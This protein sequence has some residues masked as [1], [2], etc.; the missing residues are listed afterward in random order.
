M[1]DD[2]R[3]IPPTP[4]SDTGEVIEFDADDLLEIEAVEEPELLDLDG[5]DLLLEE[6]EPANDGAGQAWS[7]GVAEAAPAE[8]AAEPLAEEAVS[9]DD[10]LLGD[11]DD[12]L[13]DEP[14]L[15]EGSL[16]GGG[17]EADTAPSPVVSREPVAVEAAEPEVLGD[18]SPEE[19]LPADFHLEDPQADTLAEGPDTMVDEGLGVALEPDDAAGLE[20]EAGAGGDVL[21][22]EGGE[23]LLPDADDDLLMDG[24]G[25]WDRVSMTGLQREAAA[26]VDGMES[27]AEARLDG[28]TF[29]EGDA[30][31]D[32]DPV[33]GEPG[34]M[35]EV[36]LLDDPAD[37]LSAA[38]AGEPADELSAALAG[39]PADE[40]SDESADE[41]MVEDAAASEAESTEPVTLPGEG[42]GAIDLELPELPEELAARSGEWLED[43][44]VWRGELQRLVRSNKWR[45]VAALSA[46]AAMRASFAQGATLA[47]ILQDLGRLYRDRLRD[48]VRAV[49]AFEALLT[50]E[51]GQAE[52]LSWLHGAWEEDGRW[53]RICTTA[54]RA[55]EA[56]WDR[57][58]RLRLTR[59]AADTAAERLGRLDLA[60]AAWEQLWSLGDGLEEATSAL[61]S[62]YRRT[63]RWEELAVFIERQVESADAATSRLLRRELAELRLFALDDADGAERLL[64]K[65]RGDSPPDAV[66][67]ELLV[68]IRTRLQRW[69]A[70]LELAE[71]PALDDA[72]RVD[73]LHRIAA[74]VREAG[75]EEDA[76]RLIDRV[77]E[78]DPRDAGALS[79]RRAWLEQ[80]GE[81][82]ALAD[83]L[84]SRAAEAVQRSEELEL[85]REAAEIAENRLEN[86][87]RAVRLRLAIRE[88]APED[89]EVLADLDRL[90][91]ATGQHGERRAV[92][93]EQARRAPDRAARV[94]ALLS[95]ARLCTG[96]GEDT[97]RAREAL[98]E[99]LRLEPSH[100][101]ALEASAAL[102]RQ[103][104]DR[105]A[106]LADMMRRYALT[107]DVEEA[108]Q[109]GAE[110]A[111]HL[112][113]ALE[114][115]ARAADAWLLVV[116]TSTR[117]GPALEALDGCL[118]DAGAGRRRALV[119]L[120]ALQ[121]VEGEEAR[122]GNL[123]QLAG[124][125][126]SSGEARLE[127]GVLE[128]LLALAEDP[129]A[130]AR[131]LE[132]YAGDGHP[133]EALDWLAAH[134]LREAPQAVRLARLEAWGARLAEDDV[135]GRF[136]L[137]RRRFLLGERRPD[138]IAELVAAG[139]AVGD[140]PTVCWLLRLHLLTQSADER[141]S[142]RDLLAELLE[143]DLEGADRAWLLRTASLASPGSVSEALEE[144]E[145]LAEQ[146]GRHEDLLAL[147]EEQALHL[148]GDAAGRR[149]ALERCEALARGPLDDPRRAIGA[150][151]RRIALD[152]PD[153]DVVGRLHTLCTG[154][155]FESALAT[156][157]GDLA[158]VA[159]SLEVR[160]HHLEEEE[161]VR[162]ALLDDAPGAFRVQ[163]QRFRLLPEA[164]FDAVIEA[165]RALGDD[166]ATLHRVLPMIE[167]SLLAAA[168]NRPA[169]AL[170]RLSAVWAQDA[171]DA[172]RG[173]ELAAEALMADPDHEDGDVHLVTMAGKAGRQEDLAMVLRIAAARASDAERRA[174]LLR[175][176]ATLYAGVLERPELAVEV[177]QR[178]LRLL[179]DDLEIVG[180]LADAARDAEDWDSL[181]R[182]LRRTVVL[183]EDR[184][185]RVA[186]QLEVATLCR[187]QLDDPEGAFTAFAG[188]LEIDPEHEEARER[189]AELVEELR[190][191]E[192]RLRWLQLELMSAEGERA[193]EL[194]LAMAALQQDELEDAEAAVG[195]LLD[196]VDHAGP[197]DEAWTRLVTL[198][199]PLGRW[200]D[201]AELQLARAE[202]LEGEERA[203]A[204]SDALR[205]CRGHRDAFESG[206]LT[207][208][209]RRALAVV[210]DDP[211]IRRDLAATLVARGALDAFAESLEEW[212]RTADSADER[213]RLLLDRA[214]V[215]ANDLD[216]G[217]GADATLT[218]AARGDGV[219]Y[220]A[221]VAVPLFQ[222]RLARLRGDWTSYLT[223]R[224]A[225]ARRLD[226]REAAL[227]F[228]H[229][230]EVCD[231]VDGLQPRMVGFYREA[232]GLDPENTCA[233]EALRGI[234]RRLKALRPAAALLPEDGERDLTLEQ[235]VERLVQ[236]ADEAGD[237][238]TE[239][240]WL[241][242]ATAIDPDRA[243]L[244]RR[245]AELQERGGEP[246]AAVQSR[247]AALRA[248]ERTTGLQDEGLR[249]DE[250]Q[251]LLAIVPALQSAGQNA[252]FAACA[253]RSFTLAPTSGSALYALAGYLLAQERET[254]LLA[255]LGELSPE[256]DDGTP[257]SL[258]SDLLCLQG[259]ALR[260]EEREEDARRALQQAIGLNPL[261]L[262][263]LDALA[264]LE[265]ESGHV[266]EALEL[267]LR[268]L[269]LDPDRSSRAPRYF[270]VGLLFEDRL[271]LHDEAGAAYEF[272]LLDGLETRGL[273]HRVLRHCRRAG[274][275]ERGLD[276]VERLLPDA[277]D[278]DELAD[279]WLARGE[280][281]SGSGDA[282]VEGDAVEA[283]DMALSYDPARHEARLGL[284]DVLRRRG[285]WEQLIE[286]LGA[287]AEGGSD[288]QRADAW[289]Q[290]AEIAQD[291][292][293]RTDQVQTY[294]RNAIDAQ[295]SARA[296]GWLL[297]ELGPRGDLSERED[298]TSRLIQ[299]G[300]PWYRPAAELGEILLNE[301]PRRAWCLLSPAMVVRE[302]EED[303]RNT[304][305]G[306][307]RD[308]EKPSLMLLGSQGEAALEESGRFAAVSAVLGSLEG[309]ADELGL[310]HTGFSG[311]SLSP[312]S[313]HS[314]LG[315]G[316]QSIVETWDIGEVSLHR[317]EEQPEPL[318]MGMLEGAPAL[319]VRAD[320]LPHLTR[321]EVG[322][323]LGGALFRL[324]SGR[325]L[326]S[327]VTARTREDLF[328]ALWAALD[329]REAERPEVA[330]LVERLREVAG[331]DRLDAWAATL[332]DHGDQDPT[333]VARDWFAEVV[334]QG[335]CAGLVAGPD[336]MQI[337]KVLSVMDDRVERP[338]AFQ[339]WEA[340]DES[341][342]PAPL[343]RG[344]LAFATSPLWRAV[345]ADA[346]EV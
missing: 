191:A 94:E 129:D 144:L 203:R 175:R 258:L 172:E 246:D 214:R 30:G 284:A 223:H 170:R 102:N 200:K 133:E 176:A 178:V 330:A 183:S 248:R 313:P 319:A 222:A 312:I 151:R 73:R 272:A 290:M 171:G 316:F 226:A 28:S 17:T 165:G 250:V 43:Q 279:L 202:A 323:V 77:L 105:E 300:P 259:L 325:R 185:E 15:G 116:D 109:V 52:V 282:S 344:L 276:L 145:R 58:E 334:H 160:L 310:P 147:V 67:A 6:V 124:F 337:W 150:L 256:D 343:L 120:A 190:S 38:L 113:E 208:F 136:D 126:S 64:A 328:L 122:Q 18:V 159:D 179:P 71:A 345:T 9:L 340:V 173:F 184:D 234:G 162:R 295:P 264:T 180:T 329:F 110:A 88:A 219:V 315:R 132:L 303:L 307:R 207:D 294:L 217:E 36:A 341:L 281:L 95:V 227:H 157:H 134:A 221:D 320:L 331:L 280:I 186:A 204:I 128:E 86:L 42:A 141:G 2:N 87:P 117:Q 13:G 266:A 260:R 84:E 16:L 127:I 249:K 254:E 55:V 189:L 106:Q 22:M 96:P 44:Q 232:R 61:A 111:R 239:L 158:V 278:A 174:A 103:L 288:A 263:A 107:E 206:E 275:L 115:P 267:H 338:M 253:E 257:A 66:E 240:D 218:Q 62:L 233:R 287:I 10:D 291:E 139:R 21:S 167:A 23:D 229:L 299:W 224:E 143:K 32:E 228:C 277:T 244:L 48:R 261:H 271:G 69:D 101:G 201:I 255:L 125:W 81:W 305:K 65:D 92:L 251:E 153:E 80:R 70:L 270:E 314:G 274:Q 68:R 8:A 1:S 238:A 104:G 123:R 198:L 100:T 54:L 37:E 169:T 3:P 193:T 14:L 51:P 27:S 216:D 89:R 192:L 121:E 297:E 60:I 336:L 235:R 20:E 164:C 268:A 265:T 292:L 83:F 47:S 163:L 245:V 289:L 230:A 39:E 19:T 149:A 187:D 99:V 53:E 90:Y 137:A 317:A 168:G 135:Q 311:I 50:V 4:G 252:L 199:P 236:L 56:N 346:I 333:E 242:R 196:L 209:F 148:S 309:I 241:Q 76:A 308:H 79:A 298:L 119:K 5:D 146:T 72:A 335:H 7:V 213:R 321:A 152:G 98:A 93:E 25:E 262:E 130:L 154:S 188:I 293:G 45:E 322:F 82:T 225:A 49:E 212:A 138:D 197:V 78:I 142:V 155:G 283:F 194:Q 302:A 131:L 140:I 29:A 339:S 247:I 177:R 285:D 231:E 166:G 75:R 182:L 296:V 91:A 26:R 118:A 306:M 63:G 195:T 31:E 301:D 342:Q 12:L 34:I 243:D 332:I 112:K 237:P 11:M 40:L 97:D 161:K 108:A 269:A 156:A 59:L 205:A 327:L 35:D 211:S 318:R 24:E 286:L 41:G 215:Q 220:G 324:R 33:G 210:P 74:A 273:M 114:D 85:L 57:D 181:R 326:A 46:H 304:L